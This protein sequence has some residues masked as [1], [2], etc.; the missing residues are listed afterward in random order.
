M[1]LAV[2]EPSP[3]QLAFNDA[4]PIPKLVPLNEKMH[5]CGEPIPWP[6]ATVD[7]YTSVKNTTCT[8]C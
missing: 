7:G 6:L 1:E 2:N 3:I 4:P 5:D 8:F